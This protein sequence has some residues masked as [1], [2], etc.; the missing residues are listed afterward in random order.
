MLHPGV[1]TE[2]R[3]I[4]LR[5]PATCSLC[6]TALPARS[7]AHWDREARAATCRSCVEADPAPTV[8]TQVVVEPE[9]SSPPTIVR[10]DAGASAARRF[11]KLHK[12]REQR[13]RERFG[14][15]S[16]IHLAGSQGERALGKHLEKLHESG[17]IIA[18]HDRRIPG[19]RAN[20]DH[21]AITRT[22]IYAIDAK[23]YAGKVQCVD[24]GGWFS[25]DWR[26][27]VG[28]RDCTK[29]VLGMA[30][31]VDAIRTAMGQPLI[32]EFD[33]KVHR[34]LCF[35]DSEW[36][37]FARPFEIKGVWV[38]WS[39]ALGERLQSEGRL[40]PEHLASIAKRV[41]KALPPA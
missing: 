31:Q 39:N 41:A 20:I 40:E 33:L 21:I 30:K 8:P 14:R 23:K 7:E 1:V 11:E 2:T 28:R 5:Y 17:A 38:G 34:A 9:S 24:K 19:M 29:L 35:V 22:G 32:E 6:G 37:L 16:A 13:S 26:L 4:R 27:Y 12:R 3:F 36:G 18:L 15:L 10:G 25:T